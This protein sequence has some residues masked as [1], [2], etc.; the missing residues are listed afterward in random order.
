MFAFYAIQIA[1][2]NHY[3]DHFNENYHNDND[4]RNFRSFIEQMRQTSP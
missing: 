1:D 2:N 4:W 3:W